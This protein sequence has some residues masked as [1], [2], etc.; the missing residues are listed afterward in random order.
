MFA[1][2]RLRME[3]LEDRAAQPIVLDRLFGEGALPTI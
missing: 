3:P 2:V 1:R